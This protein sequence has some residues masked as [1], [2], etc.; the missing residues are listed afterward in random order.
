MRV[1]LAREMQQLDR[2]AIE[3]IGIPAAVLMESA[4]RS[5]VAEMFRRDRVLAGKKVS[6][7]LFNGHFL[8]VN[9]NFRLQCLPTTE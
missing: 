4:G 8:D 5:L 1:L 6:I 2:F 3:Q 9:G 7:F